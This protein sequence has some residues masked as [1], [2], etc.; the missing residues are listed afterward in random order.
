MGQQVRRCAIQ[1]VEFFFSENFRANMG[2]VALKIV[3]CGIAKY[4][5][6]YADSLSLAIISVARIDNLFFIRRWHAPLLLI[7]P[8][9]LRAQC[10]SCYRIDQIHF[11]MSRI[12]FRI[13]SKERN[14][15]GTRDN[16]CFR[17]FNLS[18]AN[19]K[20]KPFISS[21]RLLLGARSPSNCGCAIHSNKLQWVS[22]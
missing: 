12:V 21:S 10:T 1:S 5:A 6:L 20:I 14:L 18:I 19:Y 16:F 11:L 13:D 17:E 8:H 7:I 22:M 2:C 3:I 4:H 9:W 15:N